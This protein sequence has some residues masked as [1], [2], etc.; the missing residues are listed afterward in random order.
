MF[1]LEPYK[2]DSLI[3]EAKHLNYSVQHFTAEIVDQ[4][5]C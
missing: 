3:S 2:L 4:N 5:E 1:E